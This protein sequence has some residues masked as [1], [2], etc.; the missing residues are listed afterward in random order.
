MKV[1]TVE[2]MRAIEAASD[3]AGHTYAAMMERAGRAVAEALTGRM[4][5]EGKRVLVLVG[6][7]NNG[8]DGLVA[9]HYLAQAGAEVACYLSRARDP[10]RD[11]NLRRL[12]EGSVFTTVASAD[13]GHRVLRRLAAGADVVIDG[14]LGTGSTPPVRGTVAEILK[15]VGEV[16]RRREQVSAPEI[17]PIGTVPPSPTPSR[18]LII[19]VDGPSG[20][21]FDTGALDESALRADLTVTFAYPKRGHFRFPGAAA[22]GEL[23]VADIG[24]DPAL[25]AEVDLEVA[26]PQM[27]RAWLPPRPPDAHKGTFGRALIVAGSTN[28]TGAARLAGSAAVRAG[29]G[30]VT[31]ALP[32][33]IHAPVAAGLAEATYVLLPHELGVVAEAAVEVLAEI[34]ER[35]D[36]LLLGP[37]LGREQETVAFVE[38]LLGRR[39]ERRSVGF[40]PSEKTSAPPLPLPPLVVDADGLNIL[41]GWPDWHERLP[42]GTVLTPHP[43]EMARLMGCSTREVQEDRVEVA[44]RQARAWGHVVVLKGA[45]TVVAAPDG[46]VVLEPF[47]NPGLATGG[48]GDVLAGII[49][50]LRAQGLPPFEAAVAGAYL[51][52]LAGELARVDL[53]EAG[54]AAGDLLRYLPQA[55]RRLGG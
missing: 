26:T 28:Y 47:A 25:A 16:L 50:A 46:R 54:M 42:P 39:A 53:G 43:G 52:G 31:V 24:T 34:V 51:H 35:Y 9:A 2:Q 21:D 41:S 40:L 18:P 7:G 30:L 55:Q 49:V 13:Q 23:L 1:V 5:V 37:G 44:R 3:A 11:V 12:Q 29:A 19:A 22:V 38:R 48:T 14:L 8:G 20:M 4:D 32:T 45:Y 17:Q 10:Q 15:T 36:A 27:V 33:P 6:P